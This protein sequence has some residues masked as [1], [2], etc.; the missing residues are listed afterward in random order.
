MLKNVTSSLAQ[1]SLSK[2][3]IPPVLSKI[4]GGKKELINEGKLFKIKV[5]R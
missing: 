2:H 1:S 4:G 3:R 5:S